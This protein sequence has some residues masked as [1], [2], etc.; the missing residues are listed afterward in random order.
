MV[1]A[2]KTRESNAARLRSKLLNNVAYIVNGL[3]DAGFSVGTD[4]AIIP[5]Y[6]PE[7]ADIRAISRRL[8]EAGI[9]INH[10]EYPAVPANRQRFRI[11]VMAT[12][13]RPDMD[14]L[15]SAF[16]DVFD[17]LGLRKDQPV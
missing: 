16:N 11:S 4:S 9:F 8:E 3:N 6:V 2:T 1:M 10:I 14:R 5:V 17:N 13:T 7:N 15:I 12:H